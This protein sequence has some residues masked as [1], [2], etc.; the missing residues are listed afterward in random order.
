MKKLSKNEKL[1]V[2]VEDT[3][4]LFEDVD[5]G[6]KYLETNGCDG[7]DKQYTYVPERA[8]KKYYKIR[9]T[10]GRL[11]CN[12]AYDRRLAEELNN[13]LINELDHLWCKYYF[14][15]LFNMKQE[16]AMIVKVVSSISPFTGEVFDPE[17][18]FYKIA[19]VEAGYEFVKAVKADSRTRSVKYKIVPEY[20]VEHEQSAVD[21]D[22][23]LYDLEEY[24]MIWEMACGMNSLKEKIRRLPPIKKLRSIYF[25]FYTKYIDELP[26]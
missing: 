19:T 23:Y 1:L 5:K 18:T 20:M 21:F 24:E 6:F 17:S 22:E 14:K 13:T 2:H 15:E 7:E 3:F 25:K 12:C 16:K 10:I 4:Y 8:L 26:F 9:N 11:D